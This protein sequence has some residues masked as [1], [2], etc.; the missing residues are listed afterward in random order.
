MV[1]I[2]VVNSKFI[3]ERVAYIKKSIS[4]QLKIVATLEG[5]YKETRNKT[6]IE[7]RSMK[8]ELE[9]VEV[10]LGFLHGPEHINTA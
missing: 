2:V 6:K 3:T 7:T 5:K 9:E 1:S 10:L 8:A 4:T